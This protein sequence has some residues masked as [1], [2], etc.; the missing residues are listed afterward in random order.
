M[1]EPRRTDVMRRGAAA[2]WWARAPM[3][4]TSSAIPV[5]ALG[6]FTFVLLMAPQT[7]FPLLARMRIAL[8][9][10]GVAI[11]ALVVDRVARRQPV[12]T[13]PRGAWPAVLLGSW[14]LAT[15]PL[16][17][18]PGGSVGLFRDLFVKS[19]IVM[20]LI[21][22]VVDSTRRLRRL[23]WLLCALGGLLAL[24]GIKNFAT[25]S[26]VAGGAPGAER[27]AGFDAPLTGNPND[28]ALMLNL[29]LPLTVALLLA[30]R[31][32]GARLLLAIIIG[33]EVVAI[34]ATFSRAG[35][36]TL[37]VVGTLQVVHTQRAWRKVAAIGAVAVGLAL[38][39]LVP[40]GYALHLGTVTDISSDPT[41]SA[42]ERLAL[43]GAAVRV[44]VEHPLFGAG[45][46]MNVI[47][48]TEDMGGWRTVHNVYLQIAADLGLVGLALFLVL[49]IGCVWHVRTVRREREG[50]GS[51]RDELGH[52][53][54]GIELSLVAFGIAAMFHP[55]GYHFYV[56]YIGGLALAA[57][58]IHVREG[59]HG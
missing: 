18:W 37:A 24:T 3:A 25:G 20:W 12:L 7:A 14:A 47:P 38:V 17:Y 6:G 42:Q 5:V 55:S 53:A 11:A 21:A 35:F 1:E 34:V 9:V 43:M 56:Y 19:L 39:A 8:V 15:A 57:R 54:R 50:L 44:I 58:A 59:Q 22:S 4:R 28:L 16:S 46:G 33:L 48:I 45:L 41:G 13:V 27:I 30:S 51:R 2:S 31:G 52:L 23:T 10:A 32:R 26:F 36:L 29:L 40:G 49:V